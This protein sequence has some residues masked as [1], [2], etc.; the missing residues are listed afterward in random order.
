MPTSSYGTFVFYS[1]LRLSVHYGDV[2]YYGLPM[3]LV[4]M[5]LLDGI[6]LVWPTSLREIG[7]FVFLVYSC[8]SFP[9]IHSLSYGKNI[10]ITLS[11]V[12]NFLGEGLVV[13]NLR[14][15]ILS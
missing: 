14:N 4:P 10:N 11:V 12:W 1:V 8:T 2:S 6:I 15:I 3:L 9:F 13:S 7:G 5:M